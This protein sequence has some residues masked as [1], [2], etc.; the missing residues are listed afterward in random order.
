MTFV[1]P[2]RRLTYSPRFTYD[3]RYG[4]SLVAVL[5]GGYLILSA[6]LS[7]LALALGGVSSIPPEQTAYLFL[8]YAFA[9]AVLLFGL[10]VAPGTTG[11]RVIAA[12]VALVLLVLW[13]ILFSARLTGAAGPL[14]FATGFFTAPSL[15]VPLAGATGWLIVRERPA[16]SY[17]ALLLAFLGGLIP[18][19][20]VLNAAPAI[21]AG[22]KASTLAEGVAA[23]SASIDSGAAL[24]KLDELVKCS[25]DS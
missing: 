16:I 9:V 8:Q 24:A 10:A 12:V 17:L 21:V 14:P 1:E 3:G 7:P 2:T 23:A 25:H 5:L 6:N 22:N 4:A 11:R 18:F 13:T 20:L 19:L 15:I